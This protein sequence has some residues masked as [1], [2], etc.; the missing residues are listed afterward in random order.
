[1]CAIF[2]FLNYKN[3]VEHSVLCKLIQYLANA[4]EIRGTDAT[5]IG[6]VKDGNVRIFKKAKPAHEMRLGFP[7]GTRAVTGHTRMTTQG[8]ENKNWNNHPFDGCCGKEDFALAHNGMLYNDRSLRKKFNLPET[9]IETDSYI[10]VQLLERYEKLDKDNLKLM[11]ED[12]KGSFM[13][14]ILRN[15]NTLFLVKGSNPIT[16]YHYPELGLYVYA[17]TKE[18]LNAG[19]IL[20]GIKDTYTEVKIVSGDIVEISPNGIITKGEFDD[21]YDYGYGYY[22]YGY[23]YNYGGNRSYGWGL[24]DDDYY[25]GYTSPSKSSSKSSSKTSVETVP[26][27]TT[28]VSATT[29][30]L[31][32][33]YG[34]MY[35]VTEKEVDLLLEFGYTSDEIEEMFVYPSLLQDALQEI[36]D[37]IKG[38][39]R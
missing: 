37:C 34:K 32:Y 24:D 31:L 11:A 39:Y 28:K 18:I 33:E 23:G 6:Y 17:S 1:M 36:L 15:D 5:G 12:I 9:A 19:L 10:A 7:E 2:G 20:A 16:M 8:N 13:L 26:D 27:T 38:V 21:A 25:C 4:A 29:K 22:Q 30:D 3:K 35:G 14:T